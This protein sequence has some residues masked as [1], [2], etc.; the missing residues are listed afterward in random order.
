MLGLLTQEK[1]IGK[2]ELLQL[3]EFLVSRAEESFVEGDVVRVATLVGVASYL[4]RV[5]E[6]V[7]QKSLECLMGLR[8]HDG[9]WPL[10]RHGKSELYPTVI[11]VLAL[12]E[13]WKVMKQLEAE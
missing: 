13:A 1:I 7:F 12:D 8:N 2:E 10:F 4:K 11:S 3:Y 9:G 6:P 5:T